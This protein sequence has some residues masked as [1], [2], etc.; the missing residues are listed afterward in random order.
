MSQP[1]TNIRAQKLALIAVSTLCFLALSARHFYVYGQDKSDFPDGYDAVQA[2][3]NSH[4]VVFENAF[5]RVLEVTVPPA[6]T[7]EPKHHHRWPSFFLDWDTGGG[8][9][10]VR[11][12]R[13]DGSVRDNPS[14]QEPVHPGKWSVQWMNPE[15]MHSIEVVD[16]PASATDPPGSPT[17]LRIEIK[18]HL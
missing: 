6:G 11:Y 3:P 2:A 16:R 13:P 7:T 15:P 18:C 10:H 1:K 14:R 9:P 4:K 8:S 5:V 12:H 17:S